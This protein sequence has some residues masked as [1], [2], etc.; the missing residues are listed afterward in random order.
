LTL[1]KKYAE[2]PRK[3]RKNRKPSPS[4]A[5]KEEILRRTNEL[6]RAFIKESIERLRRD[7]LDSRLSEITANKMLCQI[8]TDQ[9]ICALIDTMIEEF[10]SGQ[11][12]IA[13]SPFEIKQRLEE[14]K[15]WVSNM[16]GVRPPVCDIKQLFPEIYD[17]NEAQA[18]S[19][20]PA[21][22]P[23]NRKDRA[24]KIRVLKSMIIEDYIAKVES[25]RKG[26]GVVTK[27]DLL[28]LSAKLCNCGNP[29][30]VEAAIDAVIADVRSGQIATSDPA[31]MI[32]MLEQMKKVAMMQNVVGLQ[33]N[34]QKVFWQ[35]KDEVLVR[36]GNIPEEAPAPVME[37]VIEQPE[38]E[39]RYQIG[40]RG[41]IAARQKPENV[42]K[43]M[44]KLFKIGAEK[45]EH[46]FSGQP[47]VIK[48]NIDKARAMKYQKA[49]EQ[50]GAICYIKPFEPAVQK[51]PVA[52]PV[53]RDPQTLL[54]KA[55]NFFEQQQFEEALN[56]Y[57]EVLQLQPEKAYRVIALLQSAMCM[58]SQGQGQ[59]ALR[60]LKKVFSL[61]PDN[62]DLVLLLENVGLPLGN[63]MMVKDP[64]MRVSQF[65]AVVE[66]AFGK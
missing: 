23:G 56:C 66:G 24:P 63:N 35:D 46:L 65:F 28:N 1:L 32:P 58:I 43:R 44:S 47:V 7:T 18:P 19:E 37:N 20:A 60:L 49:I 54:A 34:S 26:F 8:A 11:N 38:P 36:G 62:Q 53:N 2:N 51:Q 17:A 41:E 30:E 59:Q 10:D 6:L 31:S 48:K 50:A 42:K 4:P 15:N 55:Q 39:R 64:G 9:E 25:A 5:Q 14:I 3:Y 21:P 33:E 52:E 29:Q 57:M 45:V 61:D 22:E 16:Q 27:E 12:V 40:F 13:G